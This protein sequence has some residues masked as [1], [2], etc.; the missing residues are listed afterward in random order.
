[1]KSSPV[2]R[3]YRL[4][5]KLL[6]LLLPVLATVVTA[7][8]DFDLS[9]SASVYIQPI[10]SSATPIT[11]L[12]DIRYDSSSLSAEIDSYEAPDLSPDSKLVRVGIYDPSSKTWKSSTTATS[13][14][15]FA[16][17]YT[18]TIILSLDAKG[19]VFGVTVKSGGVD[20]GQTRDFGPKVKLIKMVKG[21]TPE[22]NEPKIVTKEGKI[23]GEEIEKTMFQKY[24]IPVSEK[25]FHYVANALQLSDIGG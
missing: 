13:A 17:G 5:M 6:T 15:T 21:R 24:V 1:L 19:D 25:T 16:Q 3:A 7:D 10:G 9:S 2:R 12:A 8:S 18:P 14:E 11:P 4:K 22:L 23:E 20:A